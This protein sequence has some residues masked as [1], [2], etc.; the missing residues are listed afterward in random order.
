MRVPGNP[1]LENDGQ[2]CP[3][4]DVICKKKESQGRADHHC[5]NMTC[6]TGLSC[7]VEFARN[8]VLHYRRMKV[9]DSGV[10]K[11]VEFYLNRAEKQG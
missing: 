9:M 2:Q 3:R 8:F 11:R 1:A 10:S 5:V 7:A 4:S 6:W